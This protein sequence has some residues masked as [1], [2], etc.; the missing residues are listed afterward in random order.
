M[1]IKSWIEA[2]GPGG[3]VIVHLEESLAKLAFAERRYENII[4]FFSDLDVHV[5]NSVMIW[6]QYHK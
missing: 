5:I 3:L 6:R 2:I 1:F 4:V